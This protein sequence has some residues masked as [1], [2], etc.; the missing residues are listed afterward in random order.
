MAN[1]HNPSFKIVDSDSDIDRALSQGPIQPRN[2][3]YK[4]TTILVSGKIKALKFQESW[5]D[6]R[7]WLEYSETRDEASCFY[8][9]LFKP[10]TVKGS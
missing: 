8:C 2:V 6:G 1:F 10:V 4:T 7:H 9:R 5:F 3:S